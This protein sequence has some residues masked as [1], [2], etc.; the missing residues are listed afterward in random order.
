MKRCQSCSM[1]MG[2]TNE[3]YGTNADG[4]VSDDYCKYCFENGVFMSNCSLDEMIEVCVPHM[5]YA[6]DFSAGEARK[7]LREVLP[8][9]KRWEKA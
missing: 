3:L 2:T 8:T 7:M 9:L 5:T 1:P 6:T 4:S